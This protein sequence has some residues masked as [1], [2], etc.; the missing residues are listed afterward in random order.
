MV[1]P[2][3]EL[4]RELRKVSKGSFSVLYTAL[5]RVAARN[6]IY[7]PF[8]LLNKQ[9]VLDEVKTIMKEKDKKK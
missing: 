6:E 9:E 1:S 7:D 5:K 4:V 8:A 3:T 2:N